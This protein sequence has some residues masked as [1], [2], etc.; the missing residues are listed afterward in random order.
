MKKIRL[1]NL[2]LSLS[3]NIK[4]VSSVKILLLIL[5]LFV[6]LFLVVVGFFEGRKMYW[7][8]KVKTMCEKDGGVEVY[9]KI[10]IPYSKYKLL[11]KVY[12]SISI[13]PKSHVT[14]SSIVYSVINET[15][16]H[17]WNPTV[18]RREHLIKNAKK[19][20]II[21]KIVTYSRIGGDFPT[22]IG[23]QSSFACPEYKDI[24]IDQMKFF[25]VYRDIEE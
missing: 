3:R 5:M 20:K 12:G 23:H 18:V 1:D 7:D 6:L 17:K 2:G 4:G 10:R 14:D 16:V 22:G 24:Y 11:P 13:P 25:E 9:Q 21:G 8:N 15:I 19:D